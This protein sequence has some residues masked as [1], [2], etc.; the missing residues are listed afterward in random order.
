MTMK[1][2]TSRIEKMISADDHVA[3]HKKAAEGLHHVT[4]GERALVAVR[5]DQPGRGDVQR[6]AEQRG[7][8]QQRG[9]AG[10][11]QR[12][13]EEQRHHQDQ[14]GGGDGKRKA[15]VQHQGAAAAGSRTE[16]RQD[17]ADAR[18]TSIRDVGAKRSGAA[19]AG[20]A[21]VPGGG[22]LTRCGCR[23]RLGPPGPQTRA[24]R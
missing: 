5:Q 23:A 24:S 12:A 22:E 20:V 10:E 13:V 16:S 2:T 7:Q 15:E 1:F 6:Q 19:A 8:Q 18:A 4:G 3:A 9:E 14:H 21:L 11:V 17:D